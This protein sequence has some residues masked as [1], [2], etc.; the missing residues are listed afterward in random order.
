MKL[1]IDQLKQ[2]EEIPTNLEGLIQ[3]DENLSKIMAD[4]FRCPEEF[5][6]L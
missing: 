3:A 2:K 4:F 1:E 5:K 6:S